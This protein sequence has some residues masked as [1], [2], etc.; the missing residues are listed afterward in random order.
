MSIPDNCYLLLWDTANLVFDYTE[1][2]R[3]R[4]RKQS[5]SVYQD[6]KREWD[7]ELQTGIFNKNMQT[8]PQ[9]ILAQ[10]PFCRPAFGKLATMLKA[11]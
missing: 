3:P 8:H 4:F 7:S 6:R 9:L 11:Q 1:L 2:N 10:P 5:H